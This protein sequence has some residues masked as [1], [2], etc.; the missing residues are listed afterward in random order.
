MGQDSL[1]PFLERPDRGVFVLCLTSNPGARDIQLTEVSGV[2]VYRR[3]IS[4]VKDLNEN[5]NCG[6]IV[7]ATKTEQMADIR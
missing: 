7:G 4:M 2:A 6:L 3:V 5:K 1:E